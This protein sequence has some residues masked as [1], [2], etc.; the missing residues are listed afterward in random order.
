LCNCLRIRSNYKISTNTVTNF[1]FHTEGISW[2]GKQPSTATE[3]SLELV[4]DLRKKCTAFEHHDDDDL[5][6]SINKEIANIHSPFLELSTAQ[7]W[8]TWYLLD[9]KDHIFLN[10]RTPPPASNIAGTI[11]YLNHHHLQGR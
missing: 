7:W 11:N 4:T 8:N 6:G 2:P 3:E 10:F 1:G 5:S 9:V